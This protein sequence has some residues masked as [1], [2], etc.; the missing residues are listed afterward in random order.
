MSTSPMKTAI[1]TGASGGIG[2]A[3]ALRLARDGFAVAASYAGRSTAADKVVAE[4]T[5]AGGKAFAIGANV[6]DPAEVVALFSRTKENFGRVDV[7]VHSA[8]IMPL[9]RIA[10]TDIA[11]FDRVIDVNLRGAFVVL[12]EAAR[13]VENGGR[14]IALSSS[15]IA[16]A[17]P[18]Y[19]A[20]IASKAGVEGLVHVLANEL[21]GRN[22][23][24]NAVAPGPVATP[25]FLADK[26]PEQIDALARMPPLERLGQPEDI[27]DLVAFLAGPEG[28]WV[29]SQVVRS[30]GGF[31]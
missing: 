22:V 29:N 31:A 24:V 20:Y 23:A 13:Q 27:A 6:S 9:S 2:S 12:A 26:T 1:V 11:G 14:I 4:V 15:V 10:E 5:A 25:L 16:K 18:G 7:V 28:G 19:G 21:R 3:I 17:F 8:G 30:N